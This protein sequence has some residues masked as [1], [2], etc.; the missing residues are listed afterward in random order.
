MGARHKN[1]F[2]TGMT[3]NNDRFA[4]GNSMQKLDGIPKK[5]DR[6]YLNVR[7]IEGA[8]SKIKSYIINKIQGKKSEVDRFNNSS[9]TL[10]NGMRYEPS[11]NGNE[12]TFDT[13]RFMRVDDIP[14][15]RPKDNHSIT[16][17]E[18]DMI[19]SND[20]MVE[21][22]YQ[23][24]SYYKKQRERQ[25]RLPFTRRINK[26]MNKIDK[27]LITT[28][29]PYT[30]E[31]PANPYMNF[32]SSERPNERL[33]KNL[34]RLEEE[35]E[36]EKNN[37]TGLRS[38]RINANSHK[39]GLNKEQEAQ[40]RNLKQVQEKNHEKYSR[41]K[42][43]KLNNSINRT[44]E[45]AQDSGNM[46]AYQPKISSTPQKIQSK[47]ET[48]LREFQIRSQRKQGNAEKLLGINTTTK[49]NDFSPQRE[50]N[51]AIN[52]MNLSN[53]LDNRNVQKHVGAKLELGN[54]P[55]HTTYNANFF[56]QKSTEP[57]HFYPNKHTLI[58]PQDPKLGTQKEFVRGTFIGG[59]SND[60]NLNKVKINPITGVLSPLNKGS[61][62]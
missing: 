30:G 38:K 28:M 46:N 15:A 16:D 17:L 43:E 29:D 31:K 13:K 8:S 34:E 11:E 2:S 25:G 10:G 56:R 60:F 55:G 39:L 59:S 62:L 19:L 37:L 57:G 41:D 42:R 22:V 1:T 32:P 48:R 3:F 58:K 14:G 18:K 36:A 27:S 47:R 9:S 40:L 52:L 53:Q 21:H 20:Q 54:E 26:G 61:V 49:F 51:R 12:R 35:I 23:N 7:D 24:S 4:L 5:K 6:D 33:R 45:Y 50:G 44:I